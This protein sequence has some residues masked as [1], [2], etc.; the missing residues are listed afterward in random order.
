[1]KKLIIGVLT[2]ASLAA[3]LPAFAQP[4]DQREQHQQQRIDQGVRSGELTGR[5]TRH[6]ERR[7]ASI[8]HEERVMRAEHNGRLTRHDR[9]VLNHRLNRTSHAVFVK[10]HNAEVR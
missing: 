7:E 3:A 5:E 10:K 6:L 4:V 1:M 9:R 8:R 2:A